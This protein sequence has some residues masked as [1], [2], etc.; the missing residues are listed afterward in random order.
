[1]IVGSAIKTWDGKVWVLPKPARHHHVFA[2][3]WR[4]LHP[5]LSDTNNAILDDHCRRHFNDY[6]RENVSGFTTDAGEFLDRDAALEHVG[7][8]GQP[9]AEGR[10][11][12]ATKRAVPDGEI[13]GGVLTSED[14]W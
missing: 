13:I 14:L 6:I 5:G 8:C 2:E 10:I 11:C 1:M 7:T 3:I 4:S 9:F 12:S